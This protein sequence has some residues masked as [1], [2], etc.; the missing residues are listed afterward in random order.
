[1]FYT[2]SFLEVLPVYLKSNGHR[3]LASTLGRAGPNSRD[4][5]SA[6]Q[7]VL[8][9]IRLPVAVPRA[10][11]PLACQEPLGHRYSKSPAHFPATASRPVAPIPLAASL[12]CM[13]KPRMHIQACKVGHHHSWVSAHPIN[14]ILAPP[15]HGQR[16]RPALAAALQ[17][18]LIAAYF[19]ESNF[20][21]TK[22]H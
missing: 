1:M 22:V 16:R 3:W 12:A 11:C 9:W 5:A 21:R 19:E 10:A 4:V 7:D 2:D 13:C 14:R 17:S 18:M 8:S 6:I 15:G 20:N